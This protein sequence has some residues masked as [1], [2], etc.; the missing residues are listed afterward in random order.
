MKFIVDEMPVMPSLCP[1]YRNG[2][3]DANYHCTCDYFRKDGTKWNYEG[4]ECAVL[5]ESEKPD[6]D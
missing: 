3:C 5:K 4:K 2:R 1:F 6:G